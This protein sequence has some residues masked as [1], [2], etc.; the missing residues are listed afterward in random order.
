MSSLPQVFHC[1]NE[2]LAKFPFFFGHT[3]SIKLQF[4]L[5]P[6]LSLYCFSKMTAGH[7][8]RKT[9]DHA[10]W[11]LTLNS[12][13]WTSWSGFFICQAV[14]LNAP[15][16]LYSL[17]VLHI[18]PLSQTPIISSSSLTFHWR[19]HFL[20]YWKQKEKGGNTVS[21]RTCITIPAHLLA[22]ILYAL[23]CFQ[24]FHVPI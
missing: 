11:F 2:K 7:H 16:P 24:K 20:F 3:Y 22:S 12:W 21:K 10:Y 14:I 18:S 13:P 6:N 15:S 4:C 17:P 1:S 23:A 9:Y 5:N 8:G 19:P